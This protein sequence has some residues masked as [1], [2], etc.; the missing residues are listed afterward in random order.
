MTLE[1]LRKAVA[2]ANDFYFMLNGNR[3]GVECLTVDSENIFTLWHGDFEK[4][5][6]SFNEVVTD[7]VFEGKSIRDLLDERIIEID[8]A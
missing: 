1:E 5:Y 4:N 6:K 7:K 2:D 8:F 3:A